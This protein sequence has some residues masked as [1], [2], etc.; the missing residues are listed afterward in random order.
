M[1]LKFIISILLFTSLANAGA[2]KT[3]KFGDMAFTEKALFVEADGS[4]VAK[5]IG[6]VSWDGTHDVV[7]YV[8]ECMVFNSNSKKFT[9][10]KCFHKLPIGQLGIQDTL[11]IE[12]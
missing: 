9:P 5:Q 1:K 8:S 4:I 6:D 12:Q 10:N 3:K 11:V 7:I 2:P